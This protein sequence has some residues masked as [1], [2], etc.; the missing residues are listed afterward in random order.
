MSVLTFHALLLFHVFSFI[1]Y[2]PIKFD[3]CIV[4]F[5]AII[6]IYYRFYRHTFADVYTLRSLPFLFLRPFHFVAGDAKMMWLVRGLRKTKFINECLCMCRHRA[7]CLINKCRWKHEHSFQ[8]SMGV[9]WRNATF[10]SFGCCIASDQWDALFLCRC[11]IVTQS[12][13]TSI[14]MYSKFSCA[15]HCSSLNEGPHEINW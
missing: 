9:A 1:H 15:V 14:Y 5:V 10:I 11:S 4:F 2:A 6:V 7:R 8:S 13:K 12:I 3:F